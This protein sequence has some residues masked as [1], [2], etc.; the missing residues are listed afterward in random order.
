MNKRINLPYDSSFSAR[1][2]NYQAGLR[3][4]TR[5][6]KCPYSKGHKNS[7][8]LGEIIHAHN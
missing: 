6:Q 2:N 7:Q 8:S 3:R 5:T 1:R 4:R